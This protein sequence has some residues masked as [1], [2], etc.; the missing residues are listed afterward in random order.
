MGW[1][2]I[3]CPWGLRYR[4]RHLTAAESGVGLIIGIFAIFVIELVTDIFCTCLVTLQLSGSWFME[5]VA[6]AT[7]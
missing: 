5:V 3:A 4:L 6:Y 2:G 1:Y 7:N